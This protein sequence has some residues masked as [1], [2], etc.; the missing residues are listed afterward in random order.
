MLALVCLT[1][2]SA[3]VVI[4]NTLELLVG[5]KA[6]PVTSASQFSL[7][8]SSLSKLGLLGSCLEVTLILYLWCASV[9][10]LY[11][12]PFISR[13]TPRLRDTSFTQIIGNCALLLVLSSALP[14]LS[15][16]LGIT[17]FDLLGE[18]GRIEWLGSFYIVLIY[19]VFFASS[20][21]FSLTHKFTQPVRREIFKRLRKFFSSN[22]PLHTS[23]R[24][25]TSFSYDLSPSTSPFTNKGSLPPVR[26]A[27]P[28]SPSFIHNKVD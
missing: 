27:S 16:I 22:L 24:R 19:N 5:I 2:F 28:T 4:Q 14:V 8:I 11:T 1:V 13:L 21:A 23:T 20:T 18:F 9:V 10:G 15:R 25:S 3:L 6:L 12:L 7:G 17:N 26:P